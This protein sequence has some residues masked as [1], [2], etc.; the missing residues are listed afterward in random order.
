MTV[1][2]L[3]PFHFVSYDCLLCQFV[4]RISYC[5]LKMNSF[6]FNIKNREQKQRESNDGPSFSNEKL[7]ETVNS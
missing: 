7:N 2:F 4:L 1:S 5:H 6:V 3:L